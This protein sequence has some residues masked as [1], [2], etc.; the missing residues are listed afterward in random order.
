MRKCGLKPGRK[1]SA[2]EEK[3]RRGVFQQARSSREKWYLPRDGNCNHRTLPR[4]KNCCTASGNLTLDH[5]VPRKRAFKC[6]E[7]MKQHQLTAVGGRHGDRQLG[8]ALYGSLAL[9]ERRCATHVQVRGGR[10]GEEP[11]SIPSSR[12][13]FHPRYPPRTASIPPAHCICTL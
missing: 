4:M 11:G 13:H 2:A 12:P 9:A 8:E 1:N 3:Y 6:W 5:S 7:I 10:L